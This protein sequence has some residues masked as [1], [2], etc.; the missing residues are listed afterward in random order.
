LVRQVKLEIDFVWLIAR[1]SQLVAI[2]TEGRNVCLDFHAVLG[3]LIL[4]A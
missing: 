2:P 4:V 1:S 3:E